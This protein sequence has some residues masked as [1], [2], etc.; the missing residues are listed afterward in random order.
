MCAPRAPPVF[1]FLVATLLW[2]LLSRVLGVPGLTNQIVLALAV[3]W[4]FVTGTESIPPTKKEDADSA[5]VED[6][7]GKPGDNNGT[8]GSSTGSSSSSNSQG[9]N[10]HIEHHSSNIYDSN[11]DI[12]AS[13]GNATSSSSST[14]SSSNSSSSSPSTSVPD[15]GSKHNCEYMA[16]DGAYGGHSLAVVPLVVHASAPYEWPCARTL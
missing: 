9:A 1:P 8:D 13:T 2:D 10:K 7:D 4:S 3:C 15:G 14:S 6:K 16:L 12:I 5:D 11:K